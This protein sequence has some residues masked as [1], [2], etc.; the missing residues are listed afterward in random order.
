M[1]PRTPIGPM[2][3]AERLRRHIAAGT[4]LVLALFFVFQPPLITAQTH[5]ASRS[6]SRAAA[7]ASPAQERGPIQLR[8][9]GE[10]Q[11]LTRLVPVLGTPSANLP[12]FQ[13]FRFGQDFRYVLEKVPRAS[14]R[15]E[16]GFADLFEEGTWPRRMRVEL[17]GRVVLDG[18]EPAAEV[19]GTRRALVKIVEAQV[20]KQIDLRFVGLSGPAFV[21]YVRVMGLGDEI[22]IGPGAS[23]LAP[24]SGWA[25]YDPE[26]SE[27]VTDAVNFA[28]P[29]AMPLGG[30]GTGSLEI[31]A[32]G[33][34][35]NVT[36]GNTRAQPV[37]LLP[38]TFLAVRAKSQSYQGEAR[39][40]RTGTRG[41]RYTNAPLMA[42]SRYRARFPFAEIEFSDPTFPLEVRLEAFSPCVPFDWEAST[43]PAVVL[44][45]E[46]R[47]PNRSPVASAVAF[48]WEN[49]LGRGSTGR[50]AETFGQATSIVH[51]DAGSGE[52]VG[53]HLSS[54]ET[55]SDV[56][57]CFLGDQF[58]GTVTTGVVV[59]RLLHWD[60][61]APAIPWWKE[62][63]RSGRL[64]KKPSTPESW[65]TNQA[66][67]GAHATVVCAAFNLGPGEIRRVPFLV[68]WYYPRV[69]LPTPGRMG[70][71][72]VAEQFVSS[73]GVAFFTLGRL[74]ELEKHSRLWRDQLLA[75]D[76]PTWMSY[77]LLNAS[78]RLV[79]NS[80]ALRG[81]S[82]IWLA[83]SGTADL[84]ELSPALAWPAQCWARAFLPNVSFPNSGA[85]SRGARQ[86][87]PPIEDVSAQA[88]SLLERLQCQTNE[89]T[90]QARELATLAAEAQKWL[91][92]EMLGSS[93][94]DGTL[95]GE[96][97][98]SAA[99][100]L[101]PYKL[102]H[103]AATWRAL[104]LA[105]QKL[106]APSEAK[107]LTEEV[108]RLERKLREALETTSGR[109][110]SFALLWAGDWAVRSVAGEGILDNEITTAVG[111]TVAECAPQL[112]DNLSGCLPRAGDLC[113]PHLALP[114][115]AA[116]AIEVGL[117]NAGFEL[118]KRIALAAGAT[119]SNPWGAAFA[120]DCATGKAMAE[121]SH[122]MQA[123]LWTVLD[124]LAGVR[125][126]A[127]EQTLRVAAHLPLELGDH[128]SLPVFTPAFFGKL[129]VDLAEDAGRLTITRLSNE[130]NG[131]ELVIRR[132]VLGDSRSAGG[133][134]E[135]LLDQPVRLKAGDVVGWRDGRLILLDQP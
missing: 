25:P 133:M 9:V 62:F 72:R 86:G 75:S 88:A 37:S 67:A 70:E 107:R 36:V 123:S 115:L 135:V 44:F 38:G 18:F 81:R 111:Q 39:I 125:Y 130:E 80:V 108:H 98:T 122:T 103:A 82:V 116:E 65:S 19:G 69:A 121:H 126:D 134:R 74:E 17:N 59:S 113:F 29:F 35:A 20:E 22:V 132:L 7:A 15:L 104:A 117:P 21:N 106:G 30:I 89:T 52:L 56:R 58:V 92:A 50:V 93:G 53:V 100:S 77:G 78:A 10:S 42:T 124:A 43:L 71:A 49:F 28:P 63:I 6:S 73:V 128:L 76:L 47:N 87:T 46:V 5:R 34:F 112:A 64:N 90:A 97:G 60:P 95:L 4:S 14:V 54:L 119:Q 26:R 16:L 40:L 96:L 94:P 57:G 8:I 84:R 129:E 31:L 118:A 11:T 51:N 109:P 1:S 114:W 48:S 24:P 102:V 101:Q 68:S 41:R 27:I 2:S 127:R 83:A 55:P 61:I 85:A 32:D 3:S 99:E 23:R 91:K 79:A 110:H 66:K 120:V 12:L 45:V 33:A 105:Q 13:S 131:G